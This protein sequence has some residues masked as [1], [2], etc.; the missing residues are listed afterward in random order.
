LGKNIRKT[1]THLSQLPII[2]ITGS[3]LEPQQK[4]NPHYFVHTT[5]PPPKKEKIGKFTILYSLSYHS[6][7]NQTDLEFRG[8]TAKNIF[9]PSGALQLKL[10]SI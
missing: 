3:N 9:D 8:K 5:P 10:A 7:M 1:D 6:T 4:T 2:I